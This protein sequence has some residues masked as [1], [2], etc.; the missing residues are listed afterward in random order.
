MIKN[1]LGTTGTRILNAIINLAILIILT[2]EIGSDGFGTIMLILIAVTIIQL[3]VDLIAGSSLIYFSSRTDLLKLLIPSYLWIAIVISLSFL[4]FR[5]LSVFFPE[6]Y[7]IVIPSG[8]EQDI[9]LLALFNALMLTNYNLLLGHKKIGRY[10]IIFTV[11]ILTLIGVILYQIYVIGNISVIAWITGAYSSYLT[12]FMLSMLSVL[13]I[14]GSKSMVGVFQVIKKVFVFGFITQLANMLHLGNKRI[15]FYF[16]NAFTGIKAVGVYGA[17][18]QLTEGLR[19]IGQSISL[20]QFSE[21]SNSK[22]K[23]FAK[24]VT[25]KLMKFSFILTLIAVVILVSIPVDIYE[26]VFGKE[27]DNL[28]L[29]IVALSPG[30]LALS[31]NTIFS[32]YFGGLG[33]PI[34]S[35]WANGIGMIVTLILAIILIPSLGYL[36]AAITAS[37]SYLSTII[38]QYF[39]FKKET[40][41][42]FAEWLPSK[43]DLHD[44]REILK[45]IRK[46]KGEKSIK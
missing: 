12:G 34:V 37:A 16:L 10:N 28:K 7:E 18:T 9:L 41:T 14:P 44:I 27:F 35:L 39:L 22:S 33:R 23:D 19:L 8:Y 40:G 13:W 31:V 15:G 3:F 36:G 20:V 25:I 46:K 5:L 32:H 30:V 24:V 38:Y 4:I 2:R 29:V 6:L 17:G 21:I 1:I 42:V 43:N 11:Q 26:L 45:G